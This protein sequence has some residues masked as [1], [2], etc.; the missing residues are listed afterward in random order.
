MCVISS[1]TY[2]VLENTKKIDTE[3]KTVYVMSIA[4]GKITELKYAD[5]F[6]V[7]ATNVTE[8]LVTRVHNSGKELFVWTVN[9]EE[10]INKMIR[11]SVDNIITDNIEMCREIVIKRRSSN[12]V[13]DFINS[14]QE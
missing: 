11:M 14:I 6:S 3:I 12:L 9:T 2:S 5:I 1:L 7:E 10:N 13:Q 8:N 4:I